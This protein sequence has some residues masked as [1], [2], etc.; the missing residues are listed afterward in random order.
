M[1]LCPTRRVRRKDTYRH[2]LFKDVVFLPFSN[3]WPMTFFYNFVLS[4]FFFFALSDHWSRIWR[5][6]GT[7][8]FLNLFSK[9]N[10]IFAVSFWSTTILKQL[11]K[12]FYVIG[13]FCSEY[14][15]IYLFWINIFVELCN[16][17]LFY[18][19]FPF[20]LGCHEILLEQRIQIFLIVYVFIFRKDFLSY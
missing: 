8:H 6:A 18:L 15:F 12:I 10:S 17:S 13:I 19:I 7:P 20:F 4:K 9:F 11:L 2:T 14:N 5:T 3:K 1:L 16:G